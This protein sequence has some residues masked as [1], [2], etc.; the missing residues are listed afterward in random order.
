MMM[1][2]VGFF[3]CGCKGLISGVVG[4]LGTVSSLAGIHAVWMK[5]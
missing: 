2:L 4:I 3:V 1:E 5:M